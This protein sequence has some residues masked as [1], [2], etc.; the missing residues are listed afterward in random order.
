MDTRRR[1]VRLAV[2]AVCLAAAPID[3]T[4]A[5]ADA[6]GAIPPYYYRYTSDQLLDHYREQLRHRLPKGRDLYR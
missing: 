6:V 4:T 2:F 3:A 1:D 5:G